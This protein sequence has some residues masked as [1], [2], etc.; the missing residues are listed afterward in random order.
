[1]VIWKMVLSGPETGQR[2]GSH[3]LSPWMWKHTTSALQAETPGPQTDS[4]SSSPFTGPSDHLNS[5]VEDKPGPSGGQLS[6]HIQI[7]PASGEQLG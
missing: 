6:P 5:Y 3:P 2:G 1:M 4:K 7:T